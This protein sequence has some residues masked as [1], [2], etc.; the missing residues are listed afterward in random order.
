M[1]K[2]IK[3]ALFNNEIGKLETQKYN[4]EDFIEL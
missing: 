1:N 2:K 3:T 4:I